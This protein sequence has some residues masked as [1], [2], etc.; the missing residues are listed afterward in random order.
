[1]VCMDNADGLRYGSVNR[2]GLIGKL[3]AERGD[4]DERKF[5]VGD[6]WRAVY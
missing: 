5:E 1:M 4:D 3:H 2:G 6:A